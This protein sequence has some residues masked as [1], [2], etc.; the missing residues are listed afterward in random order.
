MCLRLIVLALL[1]G[2]SVSATA[3]SV[4]VNLSRDSIEARYYS[5]VGLADMTFGAL[6]NQNQ[7]D[8]AANV[9]LLATGESSPAGSRLE[10]GL[11]GKLYAVSVGGAHL[12]AL[13]LGGQFRWFPGSGSIGLG[14]YAF[15]APSIVTTMDGESFREAGVRAE[16]ELFRNSS[17]Y[18][19]Y[20][21]VR[22]DL[23]NHTRLNV[24]KGSFVGIQIKF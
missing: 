1:A 20:R 2:A 23:D 16:V 22:A 24:D 11:G 12:L 10:G 7:R 8:W 17:M 6:Y 3:D 4:D 13:G 19:G 9:G 14:G 15:Y 18:F 5:A 21:Q